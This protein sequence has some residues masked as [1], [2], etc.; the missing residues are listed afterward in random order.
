MLHLVEV[1]GEGAA[2]GGGEAV[3][4]ARDAGFEKFYAGNVVGLFELAGVDA[5]VAVGGLEDALE[6]FEAEA[7]VGGEG[8]D[9][10]E[11]NAFVDQ[12][13]ELRKLES[14]GRDV[15]SRGD[16]GFRGLAALGECSSHRTSGR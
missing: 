9:D 16:R 6:V 11:A 14:G 5:E 2:A 12:A 3:F 7:F 13:I 4:G 10:P 15:I 1:L 8:A